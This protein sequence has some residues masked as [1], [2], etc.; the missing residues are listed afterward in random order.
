[1]VIRKFDTDN[2][3]GMENKINFQTVIQFFPN[4]K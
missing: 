2:G 1:M 3:K 4:Y